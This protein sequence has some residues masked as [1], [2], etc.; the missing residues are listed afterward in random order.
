MTLTP[1][2]GGQAA[3]FC[4]HQSKRACY[5][6]LENFVWICIATWWYPGLNPTHGPNVCVISNG[7]L[8]LHGNVLVSGGL[9]GWLLWE[10]TRC[11]PHVGWSQFQT[12]PRRTHHWPKLS[13]SAKLVAPLWQQIYEGVKT[14][15]QQLGELCCTALLRK[16]HSTQS[17]S[18]GA[19]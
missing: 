1:W 15:V 9:Q 13:P 18:S 12:A 10:D 19:C 14:A 17:C 6:I 4:S 16:Q 2:K 5:S 11:W 3:A 8:D 7:I